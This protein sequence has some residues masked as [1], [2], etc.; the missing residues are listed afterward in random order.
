MCNHLLSL[1]YLSHTLTTNKYNRTDR[2]TNG[3]GRVLYYLHNYT[4]TI[5]YLDKS[6]TLDQRNVYALD[7]KGLALVSLRNYTGALAYFDKS[8]KLDPYVYG[9]LDDK[10]IG[11]AIIH[12]PVNGKCCSENRSKR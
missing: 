5:Q 12:R 7:G 10:A 11:W 2:T 1:C 6:L 9:I 8:L 4:G 3:I